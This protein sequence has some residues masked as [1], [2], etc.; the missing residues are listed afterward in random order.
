MRTFL[1]FLLFCPALCQAQ[2]DVV[3]RSLEAQRVPTPPTI[4]GK[5][6]DAVWVG[7]PVATGFVQNRPNPGM[8]SGQNTEMK[9]V[10]DDDAIYIGAYMYDSAPDSILRQ[11]SQRDNIENTDW[12]GVSFGCFQDGINGFEFIVTADG[13]QID[14]QVSP[15]GEDFNWNAVWQCNTSI[16]ADGW[17]AEFKIPYSAIRFPEAEE[18]VWDVNFFRVIRR[19]REQ[20]FWQHVDPAVA[21]FMNQSGELKGINN[22]DAPVRL[23]FYPYISGYLERA[24]DGAGQPVYGT[25]YNGGMD[26]K[27][28]LTD[29]FTLDATLIPDFGQVQSDNLVLNLSPFEVRFNENRQFFTEG[30]ELFNKGG[31]FYSRRIGGS[32]VNAYK[33]F[34]EQNE[35]EEITALPGTTQLLNAVKIS[36]RNSHGTGLGFFNAVSGKEFATLRDTI[37]G[38]TRELE[39]SPLTNYNIL[40]VDQNLP[41]NSFASIINTN[42]SRAGS[43]YDANVIGT[44]FDIRDKKNHF[45]IEGS[46]A[47]NK[48]F[49]PDVDAAYDDGYS[50]SLSLNKINGNFQTGVWHSVESDTY[51]PNDLGFLYNNNEVSTGA[52]LSYEIFEPFGP[53]NRMWSGARFS[54]SALHNPGVQTSLNWNAN[55]GANTRKFHAFGMNAGG[56]PIGNRDYFGPRTDGY[57]YQG[58]SSV[59]YNAWISTDYRKRF[60]LDLNGGGSTTS[61]EGRYGYNF[62]ISPRLRISD[63]FNVSYLYSYGNNV[64]GEGYAFQHSHPDTAVVNA[65]ENEIIYAK[66]NVVR[67]TQILNARYIFTNRMGLTFRMRHYWSTLRNKDF[68]SLNQDGSV[69]DSDFPGLREDGSSPLDQSFNAFNID[70]VYTWVFSPGSELSIVWKKS[71][72]TNMDQAERIPEW[73]DNFSQTLNAPGL[74]SFSIKIL[75]FVDY[76]TL[77]RG[78][79]AIQN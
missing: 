19:H 3:K 44:T 43:T 27:F 51:D 74:D 45:N 68:L 24:T 17:I 48:K 12:V 55:L 64:N 28:G 6:D 33:A 9:V 36:G 54:R 37:T 32:P 13:V 8:A 57:F 71:I 65:Y 78:E 4:D 67:H 23:F 1:L 79:K 72:A 69:S 40:V 22:V 61:Q 14:A 49:G 7:V 58:P 2:A 46:G 59:W 18:Q 70:L 76:L 11:L 15:N 62:R 20:S 10:Y 39:V 47:Y 50:W 5:L 30:T 21:G 35:N 63:K 66:R 25:S 77:R 53:F 73:N 26:L 60:A 16:V 34:D 52:R 75:Y 38:E 56:N 31:L 29:A 41:N 42:V